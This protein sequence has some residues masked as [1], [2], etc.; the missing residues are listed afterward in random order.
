MMWIF[1]QLATGRDISG[2]INMKWVDCVKKKKILCVDG[3]LTSL[4]S[5][6]FFRNGVFNLQSAP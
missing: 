4:I 6:F 5:I 1:A 2:N 3:R